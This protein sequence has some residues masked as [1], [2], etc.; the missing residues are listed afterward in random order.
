[1]SKQGQKRETSGGKKKKKETYQQRTDELE[2]KG[3]G[4]QHCM[5]AEAGGSQQVQGQS[6]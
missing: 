4:T 2:K 3:L 5:Q 1:M 6:E